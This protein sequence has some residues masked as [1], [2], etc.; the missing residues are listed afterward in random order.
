MLFQFEHV[1]R[2]ANIGI[3]IML[4]LEFLQQVAISNGNPYFANVDG[5]LYDHFI[6]FTVCI[7]PLYVLDLPLP[8]SSLALPESSLALET[9]FYFTFI[10]V[11]I[12]K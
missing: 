9:P 6:V 4:M 12:I 1:Q 5:K 10:N 7:C 11:C 2:M 8:E 3:T